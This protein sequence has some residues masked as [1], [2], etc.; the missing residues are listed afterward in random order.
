M[1]LLKLVLEVIQLLGIDHKVTN[2]EH[3]S[4]YSIIIMLSHTI[5]LLYAVRTSKL[6]RGLHLGH[7]K[8]DFIATSLLLFEMY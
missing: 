8:L 7:L 5:S 3:F 2:H 1:F 4:N 6:K